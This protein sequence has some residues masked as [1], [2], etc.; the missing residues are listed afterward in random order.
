VAPRNARTTSCLQHDAF[1]KEATPKPPPSPIRHAGLRWFTPGDNTPRVGE[2]S[3]LH[4]D[5]SMEE[6][7]ARRRRRRRHRHKSGRTFVQSYHTPNDPTHGQHKALKAGN[8][9]TSPSE[10]RGPPPPQQESDG[11]RGLPPPTVAAPHADPRT[12]QPPTSRKQ[13]PRTDQIGP[14]WPKSGPH[15]RSPSGSPRLLPSMAAAPPPRF[16]AAAPIP[17]RRRA[18][19][20]GSALPRDP[21]KCSL[22]AR[23]GCRGGRA[24]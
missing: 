20:R 13:Q 3:E 21:P 23:R 14:A 4:S 15:A 7:D 16:L 8:T 1:N 6:N 19:R 10:I 9:L 24:S 2:M 18:S 11:V 17:Q 5:A 12:K 22:S